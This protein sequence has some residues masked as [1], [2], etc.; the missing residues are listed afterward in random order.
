MVHVDSSLEEKVKVMV[1]IAVMKTKVGMKRY[2]HHSAYLGGQD[3]V[4]EEEDDEDE[5]AKKRFVRKEGWSE[6]H[7]ATGDHLISMMTIMMTMA[8]HW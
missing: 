7:Q 6:R 5:E 8:L 2:Q 1:A 3:E 4:N